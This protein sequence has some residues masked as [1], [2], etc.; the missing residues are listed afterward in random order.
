[1]LPRLRGPVLAELELGAAARDLEAHRRERLERA[2]IERISRVECR[3]A[4]LRLVARE[5]P[6]LL[7]RDGDRILDHGGVALEDHRPMVRG[8]RT[9]VLRVHPV[10][11]DH[12]QDLVHL[13]EAAGPR[14]QVLHLLVDPHQVEVEGRA[15]VHERIEPEV[16][17]AVRAERHE[18]AE[19]LALD[20]PVD[21]GARD[22]RVIVVEDQAATRAREA[23]SQKYR[24]NAGSSVSSGWNVATSTLPWRAITGSPW[25]S[26]SVSTPTPT[27]RIRGARMKTIS[28]GCARPSS[29]TVPDPAQASRWRP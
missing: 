25:C 14:R 29:V 24:C 8:R 7:G 11:G 3:V 18:A 22:V 16:R 6:A 5:E 19:L 28:S 23:T 12:T 13:H 10:G 27:R 2:A 20:E 17:R 9:G 15:L 1:A 21:L 26:A 4:T